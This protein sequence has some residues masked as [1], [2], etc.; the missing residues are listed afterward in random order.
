MSTCS[1]L[2]SQPECGQ[3]L[4]TTQWFRPKRR[5]GAAAHCGPRV[6]AP[7]CLPTPPCSFGGWRRH[8]P[9]PKCGPAPCPDHRASKYAKV[10]GWAG[11]AGA[12]GPRRQAGVVPGRGLGPSTVGQG[13]R[14]ADHGSPSKQ[15]PSQNTKANPKPAMQELGSKAAGQVAHHHCTDA[16][17]ERIPH[18]NLKQP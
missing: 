11:L 2:Q 12:G 17:I 14:A 1:Q 13:R 3:R 10:I 4:N 8:H 7:P 9:K 18:Q 5:P 15:A 16:V 6:I